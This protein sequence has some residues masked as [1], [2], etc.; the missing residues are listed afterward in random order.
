M[1]VKTSNEGVLKISSVPLKKMESFI[2][3]E[4][5]KSEAGGVLLGRLIINSKN[6]IIDR[7]SV[8][9]VGDQR[10]RTHFSRAEKRH[11]QIITTAWNKS[12]ETCH[13]LGEW[14]THPEFYPTPSQQDKRNWREILENRTFSSLYLYFVIVGEKETRVWEG[15]HKTRKIKRLYG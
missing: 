7:I 3:D 15:N 9:M 6:I 11:Q 12:N 1:I 13:Y 2:Q 14:H 5:S 8:P 10:S 4:R